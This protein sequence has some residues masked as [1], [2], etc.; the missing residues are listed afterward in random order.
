MP[1]VEKLES[2]RKCALEKYTVHS[3]ADLNQILG[4]EDILGD[5]VITNYNDAILKLDELK[6]IEGLLEIRDSP[7]LVRIELPRLELIS[8]EFK[9]HE[10]TSLGFLQVPS[11]SAASKIHWNVLPIL[12]AVDI[13]FERIDQLSSLLISDTSLSYIMGI[14]SSKMSLFNINNNRYLESISADIE[15]VSDMLHIAANGDH[16]NVDLPRLQSTKNLSIH[17]VDQLDLKELKECKGSMSLDKNH[18]TSVELP[19]LTKVAGTLSLNNNKKLTNVLFDKLEDVDGGLVLANNSLLHTIDFF[20]ELS[21]IGGALELVGPIKS[22]KMPNLRL[23]RGSAKIKSTD[24]SFDCLAWSKSSI[25][26]VIRGGK[27]ECTNS[28][29]QNY[30]ANTPT[31]PNSTGGP[32]E[33]IASESKALSVVSYFSLMVLLFVSLFVT[34]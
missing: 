17:N 22:V 11:L 4:C 16:I 7:D 34:M 26:A 21:V 8:G 10:L 33:M 2:L 5:I 23:V 30:I 25:S 13:V 15:S 14:T 9:L 24:E 29:N 19:K 32:L 28:Q 6:Y 20:P 27:N 12:S 1:V 18:L 31:D 3:V